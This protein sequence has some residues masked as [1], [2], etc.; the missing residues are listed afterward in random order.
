MCYNKV[1]KTKANDPEDDCP[2][3]IDR[4]DEPPAL[5]ERNDSWSDTSSNDGESRNERSVVISTNPFFQ[6]RSEEAQ[7]G[8]VHTHYLRV[9]A[10]VLPLNG[11]IPLASSSFFPNG[12]VQPGSYFF[13]FTCNREDI[14]EFDASA[15]STSN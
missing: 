8:L 9:A 1:G 6:F 4:E 10:Q 3:L 11:N 12:R 13:T 2:S 7:Q 15:S 14:F 5:I